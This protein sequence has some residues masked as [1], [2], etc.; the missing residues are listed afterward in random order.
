M[1]CPICGRQTK[2]TKKDYMYVESGLDNVV[3]AGINVFECECGESFPEIKNIRAVH[4]NIALAIV[5]KPGFLSGK[6]FRFVRKQMGLK[7]IEIAQL[8]G[9]TPVS[10]SRWERSNA[11]IGVS[12]DR[13]IRMLYVQQVEEETNQVLRGIVESIKS[14]KEHKKETVITI[15]NNIVKHDLR[16][17][18]PVVLVHPGDVTSRA[19][20][21]GYVKEEVAALVEKNVTSERRKETRSL[22]KEFGCSVLDYRATTIRHAY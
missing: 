17:A 4:K 11:P 22:V 13:L 12:N 5:R 7:E 19:F 21:A 10:V 8:L 3:L 18:R 9:V 1:K 2:K 6:E 14:I 16:L 15:P 20:F